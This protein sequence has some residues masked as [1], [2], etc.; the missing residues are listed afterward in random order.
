MGFATI[1]F[2]QNPEWLETDSADA[3]SSRIN[4]D[5]PYTVS[6]IK[7]KKDFLDSK[8]VDKYI[9]K[10]YIEMKRIY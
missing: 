3:I 9:K 4:R 5:F 6:E 10:G 1:S 8:T 7:Q 2:A